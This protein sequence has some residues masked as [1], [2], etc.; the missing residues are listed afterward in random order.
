MKVSPAKRTINFYTRIKFCL[1]LTATEQALSMSTNRK[2]LP[3]F[4]Q[5]S[6]SDVLSD[7][8]SAKLSNHFP[9]L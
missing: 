9:A 3:G 8:I 5:A 2:S 7:I 6:F 1:N 4:T